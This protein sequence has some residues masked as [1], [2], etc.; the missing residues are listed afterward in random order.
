MSFAD[1]DNMRQEQVFKEFDRDGNGF[2]DSSELELCFKK[3][4]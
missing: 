2:I 1:Y 4:G 3:L